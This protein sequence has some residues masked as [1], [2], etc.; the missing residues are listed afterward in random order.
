MASQALPAA[1]E[2]P[3]TPLLTEFTIRVREQ[4]TPGQVLDA[5]HDLA[6]RCGHLSVLGAARFPVKAS[7]WRSA[8]LERD[9]FLHSSA[10]EG[11]VG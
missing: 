9:V 8:R 11:L 5:L 7:D 4:S 6:S 3:V 10:P 2:F 1:A